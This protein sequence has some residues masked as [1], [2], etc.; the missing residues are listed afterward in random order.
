MKAADFTLQNTRLIKGLAPASGG[1]FAE[2]GGAI[3]MGSGITGNGGGEVRIISC[4][5]E[6]NSLANLNSAERGGGAIY[7]YRLRNLIIS[8]SSFTG[9]SANV[10]GAIAGLGS[11]VILVNTDFINNEAA[12]PEAFLSGVGG[13][14][15]LDGIDLW[16]LADNQNHIF[17]VCGSV[18]TGNEGKHE[19]GAIY[20]AI[21]DS[22]RNQV[23]I[24]RSHFENN[25]LVS[26]D[27]GNGGAIFHVEDDYA[28][29]AN[30]PAENFIL[31]NSSFVNNTCP[32]QGGHSGP[33]LVVVD[34][35]KTLPLRV[36]PLPVLGLP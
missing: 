17:S 27:N 2:S 21:S 24:D 32:R 15:Y 31:T 23:V 4:Q 30:D 26:P 34:E 28:G 36:M 25:R 22:K 11:Q 14:V 1:L 8:E 29:N 5:F 7:A 33:S 6:N 12:G 20:T 3:L 35:L 19:G 13:A 16:D 10:G 9:N 18:F